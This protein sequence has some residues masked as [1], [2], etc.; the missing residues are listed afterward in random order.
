MEHPGLK[1]IEM[2]VTTRCNKSC[3][4]CSNGIPYTEL[5][6]MKYIEF[7]YYIKLLLRNVKVVEKFQ[8]HGGE[9]LLNPEIHKIIEYVK[10]CKQL[11]NVR[12][13]T[14]GTIIPSKNTIEALKNSNITI[15]ISSYFFNQKDKIKLSKLLE[16]NN[17][18]YILYG[19]QPWYKFDSN[20]TLVNRFELCPIN[21]C[22]SYYQGKIYLCSRISNLYK[23][24]AKDCC[25]DLETF[26][27][28]L[29]REMS[30]NRLKEPCR[31]CNISNQMILAG[32]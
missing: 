10:K 6:D 29:I 12:L 13:V 24:K 22:P 11:I 20:Q 16:A 18:K 30:S 17:I 25:V 21:S 8:I 1:Y 15:A 4:S 32:L 5:Y 31:Y 23:E 9:P 2:I 3:S 19:E 28:D 7:K 26:Q 14:N 27:G